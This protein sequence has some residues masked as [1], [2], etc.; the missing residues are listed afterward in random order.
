MSEPLQNSQQLEDLHRQLAELRAEK[1]R[2][3]SEYQ[4]QAWEMAGR[5]SKGRGSG[6]KHFRLIVQ[7][8]LI[9]C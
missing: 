7:Q 5:A 3:I 9:V 4:A 1:N 8:Q 6:N 2:Q